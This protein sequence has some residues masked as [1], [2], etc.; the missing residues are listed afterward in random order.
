MN[1][2]SWTNYSDA[3]VELDNLMEGVSEQMLALELAEA[4]LAELCATTVEERAKH[5]RGS[6]MGGVINLDNIK[7]VRIKIMETKLAEA[8]TKLA[9]VRAE[10]LKLRSRTVEARA[11]LERIMLA[12]KTRAEKD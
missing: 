3:S 12:A 2:G 11:K 1:K 5:E 10:L 8:R 9:E 7:E 4:Q 6:Y